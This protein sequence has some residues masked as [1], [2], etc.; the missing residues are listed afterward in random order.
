MV[1]RGYVA[2]YRFTKTSSVLFLVMIFLLIA[3]TAISATLYTAGVLN[4]GNSTINPFSVTNASCNDSGIF[5]SLHSNLNQ[6]VSVSSVELLGLNRTVRFINQNTQQQSFLV[7]AKA[8]VPLFSAG[9]YC[10]SFN[11]LKEISLN[12]VFNSTSTVIYTFGNNYWISLISNN[13]SNIS[14][15]SH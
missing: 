11:T 10:P 15:T 3:A 6:A 13:Y 8:A 9:Y 2:D 4:A 14:E 7:S 1:K 12:V 5:V